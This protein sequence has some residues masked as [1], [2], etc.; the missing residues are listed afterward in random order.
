MW[1]FNDELVAKAIYDSEIPIISA[2]GH[3]PDVTIADYVADVRAATPSNGAELAVPDQDGL[4]QTMDAYLASIST[5]LTRQIKAARKHLEVLS[6]SQSL[7]SPEQ[8][9]SVLRKSLSH[10]NTM[11]LSLQKQIVSKNR[12][13]FLTSAAK[14]DAMSPL[15]VL[16]RGYSLAQNSEGMI[17]RSIKQVKPTDI[18]TVSVCDGTITATVTETKGDKYE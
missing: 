8:Y 2:V 7:R 4:R 1:A 6:S 10:Q 12:Q 5:S 17:L 18:I 13:R 14:L 11:L 15:K 16:T 9:I 3:E